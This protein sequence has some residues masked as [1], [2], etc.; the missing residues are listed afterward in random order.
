MVFANELIAIIKNAC[1]CSEQLK[2]IKL[3]TKEALE[4]IDNDKN[5][6][7]KNI[8]VSIE[9]PIKPNKGQ[10]KSYYQ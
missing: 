5:N 10:Y 9:N 6:Y 8:V 1:I 4:V 2:F 7:I 3:W